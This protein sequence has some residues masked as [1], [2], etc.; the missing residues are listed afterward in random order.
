MLNL[1]DKEKIKKLDKSNV[2]GSVEDLYKQCT[3]A[4]RDTKNLSVP[5]SYRQVNKILLTGMGGSGLGARIIESVYGPS[6]K[7]PIARLNEYDLPYW[8]DENTLVICSS[9]SGTTEETV[10]NA[11]QSQKRGAK[12]MAIGT[13][14]TLIELAKKFNVPFYQIVPTYNSSKQPRLAIGYSV[15]GQ[16]VMTSRT[17]LFNLSEKE[18][19]KIVSILKRTV[20]DLNLSVGMAKNKAKQVAKQI[21]EKKVIFVAARHLI[22]AAHTA[23]NQM[24]ENAKHF[25][26]IFDIP[27]LNH[28]LM[29]GLRF[30]TSNRKDLIFVFVKSK[31]YPKRIQERVEI[32]EEVVRKN[33]I[34]TITW[35]A[36][37]EDLL[38]Q[39]FEFIQFFAY[40]N[41]YLSMLNNLDPAPIPWV[42]YF[43]TKLGQPLGK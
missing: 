26:A 21:Y 27:E 23:K 30:P 22:A 31:L 15:V 7:F 24:N 2:Y 33:N 11:K 32:T 18:V 42:D 10:E 1:D 37:S 41:F 13:G 36:K 38:S 6:L 14:E 9:F 43:K 12:W 5:S 8:V 40:V 25:S 17:G 16:L 34:K 35:S 4:W 19:Q 20:N 29:E 39:V 3:H 28:H